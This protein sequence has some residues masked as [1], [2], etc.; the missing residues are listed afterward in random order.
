VIAVPAAAVARRRTAAAGC[1]KRD[2]CSQPYLLQLLDVCEHHLVCVRPSY[3]RHNKR[4]EKKMCSQLYLL[5]PLRVATQQPNDLYPAQ[6]DITI[7]QPKTTDI[8]AKNHTVTAYLLQP[9]RIATQQPRDANKDI[10]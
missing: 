7:Q 5:Q 8:T 6:S 9:L 4:Q 3:H 1:Q 2:V 10:T